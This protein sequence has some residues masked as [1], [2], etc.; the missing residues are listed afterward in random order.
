MPYQSFDELSASYEKWLTRQ[1]NQNYT[2]EEFDIESVK[3]KA[4]DYAESKGYF[5][6]SC[7]SQSSMGY[8]CITDGFIQGYIQALK[9]K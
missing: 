2:K 7:A 4:Q 6:G 5:A 8:N 1:D 9:E 3:K